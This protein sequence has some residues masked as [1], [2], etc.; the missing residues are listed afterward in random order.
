MFDSLKREAAMIIDEVIQLAYWMRGGIGYEE[1][2]RRSPIERERISD[3]I[4]KRLEQESKRS[5]PSY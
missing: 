4:S 3:F 1:L 5:S 2:M